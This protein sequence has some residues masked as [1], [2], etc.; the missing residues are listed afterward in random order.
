MLTFRRFLLMFPLCVFAACS[1]VQELK[2]ASQHDTGSFADSLAAEYLGFSE[3]EAEQGREAASE[4]FALKGLDAKKN[5][6][7]EPERPREWQMEAT[8]DRDDL[9]GAR[10]RLMQA[11]TDFVKRVSS[12]SL[13]RAQVLYDC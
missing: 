8:D 6:D 4:H 3:S 2:Q 7:V 12:Q 13:A 10:R 1:P 9:Q 11:R 5:G